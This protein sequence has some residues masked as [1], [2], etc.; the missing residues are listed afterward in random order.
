MSSPTGASTPNE[1]W[2]PHARTLGCHVVPAWALARSEVPVDGKN[3]SPG[4]SRS[5]PDFGGGRDGQAAT[6]GI[7]ER[8]W[9]RAS[10]AWT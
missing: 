7:R 4:A 2:G 6:V 10:L 9:V 5:W 3:G 1:P 8:S